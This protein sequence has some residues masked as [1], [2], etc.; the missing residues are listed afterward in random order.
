MRALKRTAL[1]V[2]VVALTFVSAACGDD[3]D[4][5]AAETPSTETVAEPTEEHCTADHVGGTITMGVY[6][7]TAGLDPVVSTGSGATGGTELAAIYDTIMRWDP[8]TGE[9]EPRL[10]ESL[11]PNSDYSEW[12]LKL[13]PGLKFGNGDP[14]TTAAVAHSIER[15][16]D[17]DLRSSSRVFAQY[18]DSVEIVDDLTMVFKLA[19]PWSEF[20][21]V[22][23][24]EPG[25]VPNPAVIEQLG[26]EQFSRAPVGAGVGPYEVERFTPGESIVLRAKSD[27]WGGPVCVEE[28]RFV[29]WGS[30]AATFEALE[31]GQV[32]VAYIDDAQVLHRLRERGFAHHSEALGG[33][34]LQ[35][36]QNEG[37][38]TQHLEVR[39]A[40]LH[41]LDP[42]VIDQRVNDGVGLAT[43]KLF[44][45]NSLYHTDVEGPEVDTEKA[46]QL[47]ADAKAAHGWDG[48]VRLTCTEAQ[49]DQAISVKTLL[50]AVGFEVQIERVPTTGDLIQRVF[51]DRNFD[52]ACW[53]V[54]LFDAAPWVKLDRMLRNGSPSNIIGYNNP[55]MEAAL[56][57][58]RV[59]PNLD[60]KKRVIGEI[61]QIWNETAPFAVIRS[62]EPSI[63]WR[64]E[65][66]GL[67]FTQET[68][69]YFDK[70]YIAR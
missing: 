31:A 47:V 22:L 1:G 65:V 8:A 45:E 63:A 48:K 25:M 51:I 13:K 66:R 26:P 62:G 43:S 37:A 44:G 46:A 40:I 12:T 4:T 60:A 20:P 27:Y 67:T 29:A 35:I 5:E 14:F 9:Y 16:K 23:A 59:A 39:Q 64:D 50:D 15:H 38:P 70:A 6:S 68:I 21:Y 53:T 34:G 3:G 57:E 17:P 54:Q 69:V 33:Q 10:A 30:P 18:I 28:L 2:A 61:Q 42:E 19:A 41:A 36:N 55:E 7:E 58:L 49:A 52:M 56:A 11:E 32:N 24:D